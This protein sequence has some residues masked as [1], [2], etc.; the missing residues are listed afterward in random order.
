MV[1]NLRL[2][3]TVFISGDVES[4]RKLL[5]EKTQFRE[6]ERRMSDSHLERLRRGKQESIETSPL[7]LDILRDFK[8]INSHITSVAY[9]ILDQA[10]ELRESWLRRNTA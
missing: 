10:G 2:A 7:H 1:E 8:R 9:P 4:A 6:L 3:M 5:E